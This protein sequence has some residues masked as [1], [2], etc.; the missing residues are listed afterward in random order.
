MAAV[1][2]I[3][4][5]IEGMKHALSAMLSEH[6]AQ[7][8]ADMQAAVEEFCRPDNIKKIVS[9][10]AHATMKSAIEEEVRKFFSYGEGRKAVAETVKARLLRKD[11]YTPID[12]AE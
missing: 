6:S 4:I 12:E 8:D 9:D 2:V 5:E 11:T 10:I 3:R 7:L 1:P